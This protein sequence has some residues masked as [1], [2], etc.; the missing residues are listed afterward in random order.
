MYA[1]VRRCV[2]PG[3]KIKHLDEAPIGL[4]CVSEKEKKFMQDRNTVVWVKYNGDWIS[5][6]VSNDIFVRAYPITKEEYETDLE[7]DLYDKLRITRRPI[8][9]WFRNPKNKRRLFNWNLVVAGIVSL[10]GAF[11]LAEQSI[12]GDFGGYTA[13]IMMLHAL[14]SLFFLWRDIG[15]KSSGLK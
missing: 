11:F 7:F 12:G 8:R 10:P 3:N 9:S 4:V 1:R 15:R 14:V 6:D 5:S 13:V 2:R